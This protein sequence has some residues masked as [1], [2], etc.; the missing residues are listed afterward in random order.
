MKEGGQTLNLEQQS[1]HLTVV[2]V[3][4]NSPTEVPI[5]YSFI[6][7]GEGGFNIIILYCYNWYNM[8]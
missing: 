6:Q 3:Q 2:W 5:S 8:M 7:F 1:C 4:Y